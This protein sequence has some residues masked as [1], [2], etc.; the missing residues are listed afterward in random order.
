MQQEKP[1]LFPPSVKFDYSSS[2]STST[3]RKHL[4]KK[5]EKEFVEACV[6]FN[7]DVPQPQSDGNMGPI[8]SAPLPG[9]EPFSSEALLKHIINFIIADDQVSS[10]LYIQLFITLISLSSGHQCCRVPG[11]SPTSTSSPRGFSRRR[12]PKARQDPE[13]NNKGLACVL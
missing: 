10:G 13:C 1:N 4:M 2:T 6:K 5:H 11:I 9:R 8:S 7:W 12:Y 3:L